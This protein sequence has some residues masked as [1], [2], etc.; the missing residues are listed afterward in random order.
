MTHHPVPPPLVEAR[1]TRAEQARTCPDTMIGHH[2]WLDVT[3]LTDCGRMA[4]YACGR[5]AAEAEEPLVQRP[6]SESD[7]PDPLTA[8]EETVI[9]R[10]VDAWNA[11]LRLP[12]EHADDCTEFRQ[13]VHAAQDKVL[14]RAG[15]R[16]LNKVK[17]PQ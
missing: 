7:R 5:C 9:S 11:F 13:L 16:W 17:A 14:A 1:L 4:R 8:G 3:V 2:D 15:R 12:V 10:L 6:S